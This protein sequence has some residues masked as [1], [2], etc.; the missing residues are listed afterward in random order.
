V[1]DK[2]STLE[3]G[4]S[5]L[6]SSRLAGFAGAA[7]RTGAWALHLPGDRVTWTPELE[8]VF[9]IERGSFAGTRDAFHALVYPAD[10]P[11]LQGEIARSLA[12]GGEYC[13]VFRYRHASGE[14]RWMEGRGLP[15]F[16]AAGTPIRIDGIGI[17]VTDR[18]QAENARFRLAA[19]VESSD[20]A[21]L[22]KTLEGIVTSWNAGATRLFG[23]TAQE[24]IGEPIL[25]LVPPELHA[26]EGE[27][28]AKLR[29]GERID[30][31]ETR[32][33]AKDGSLVEVSLTVSPVRDITGAV[34]G[35]SKIAR[36]IGGLR[37]TMAE[38]EQLL[39]SERNAR[40]DAER[41]GHLK[42]EF[43]ATL[44]HEL[45]TPL[46]AIMGWATLLRRHASLPEAQVAT[47]VETI[48]RNA[49]AQAQI[50][51]DLLDMSRIVSGKIRLQTEALD[52]MELVQG[53]VEGIVPAASA[54]QIRLELALAP[55]AVLVSGDAGRLQQVLWNLLTN[56]VKFTPMGGLITL[57]VGMTDEQVEVRVRDSGIGI[58]R[59]FLPHVFERFRQADGSTTREH[60]GLG[61]GLSIVRNL[62][63]L[64][65]GSVAVHSEGEGCGAE[66]IVRLPLLRVERFQR[67]ADVSQQPAAEAHPPLLSGAVLLIVDDEPDGRALLGRLMRDAGATVHEA[68]AAAAGMAVLQ[69]T[70]I[71][72]ILSDIGMPEMDGFEFIR[73]VRALGDPRKRAT[74]AIAVTAYARQEDRE[75]CMAAGFQ[76]HVA[77]PY[78]FP[79]LVSA[80]ALLLES[81]PGL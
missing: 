21:I 24:M 46:T 4:V 13:V 15:V 31:Y 32:R 70:A 38:R 8:D 69:G 2:N 47:A 57:R 48:Y 79:E 75:R 30:H 76:R 11:R 59:E 5:D 72:L 12:S 61:L 52:L 27:I 77:K 78:S 23:Y 39:E 10:L 29:R 41:L 65:G 37:R 9:G 74:P 56:A 66:F 43:L 53:A 18:T 73:R 49:R 55:D 14:W 26:E 1:N 50:I 58:A 54:R 45:R 36:D 34:V 33:M 64:H 19:I 16:D 62:V 63:E 6:S 44:S 3:A 7:A 22:S 67:R 20:D 35:A 71:D 81:R 25:K 40:A 60:G 51:E 17:D 68:D 80:I 42:D 28:L